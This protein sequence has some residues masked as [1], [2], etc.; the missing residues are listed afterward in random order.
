MRGERFAQSLEGTHDIQADFDGAGGVQNG[1]GHERAV[2]GE[3]E[4]RAAQPLFL[5]PD[6]AVC[7]LLFYFFATRATLNPCNTTF[8]G[9]TWPT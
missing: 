6:T 8:G 2:F 4:R 5:R 1:G 9:R 3:R 7:F